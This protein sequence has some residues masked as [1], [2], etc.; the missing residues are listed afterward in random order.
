MEV[1]GQS[2][3][4]IGR[5]LVWTRWSREKFPAPTGTE[6]AQYCAV[7]NSCDRGNKSG[8]INGG[9]FLY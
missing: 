8:Y 1:S 4:P 5:R 7:A 9:E 3:V 6:L 2:L